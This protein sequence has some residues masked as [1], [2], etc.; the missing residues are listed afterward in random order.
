[1]TITTGQWYDYK[2]I[3]DR[4]TG[5]MDVY[6][7]NNFVGSWTDPAPLA[8]GNAISFRSGNCDYMINDLKVYRSRPASVTVS[9]G[10]ASTKDVRYQN[11]DPAT[12]SCRIKSITKD[13]IG[14]LSAVASQNVNVDWTIPSSTF[15][16]DGTSAD[17]DTTYSLTQLSA[18]W[19][20][21]VDTN[22]DISRY[23]YAIGT[24]SGATNVL[25]WTDNSLNTT[26]TKTGLT[27]TPN[28]MY[29]FS[30]KSEDGAGLIS[31]I[32]NSDG[33]L[34]LFPTTIN[35]LENN[36]NLIVYPN[37]FNENATVAYD[38]QNVSSIEIAL[39]DILGKQIVLL[40]KQNQQSGKQTLT[41][42][43]SDLNLAKGIYTLTVRINGTEKN[44][45]LISN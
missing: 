23:W 40:P 10:S 45:K 19:T 31:T 18:N 4:I 32:T 3:Y 8:N 16:D 24:T 22:S 39:T 35:E 14:N 29:Y 11:P 21:C 5:K 7:N 25:G 36:L 28:Q 27:L 41:I 44:Y 34:V 6:Q 15:I 2:V 1:M 26:V 33:Q 13:S 12:P 30:V 38:L 42:N 9:V 20:A 43:K 17:I 37:P